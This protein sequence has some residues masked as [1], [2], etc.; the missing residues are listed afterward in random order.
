MTHPLNIAELVR[1]L[2]RGWDTYTFCHKRVFNKFVQSNLGRGL[3][4]STRT[5]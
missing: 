5:P 1:S 3:R 4:E 2:C